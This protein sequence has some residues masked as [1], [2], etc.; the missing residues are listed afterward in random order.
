MSRLG[1]WFKLRMGGLLHIAVSYGYVFL[2]HYVAE[3]HP[4]CG[5][6]IAYEGKVRAELSTY[7]SA[8]N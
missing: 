4:D 2:S 6:F 3:F 8:V 7:S 5:L 1:D